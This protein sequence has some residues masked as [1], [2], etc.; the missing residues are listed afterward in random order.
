MENVS[1]E[2]K[3]KYLE[4][5]ADS[6]KVKDKRIDELTVGDWPYMSDYQKSKFK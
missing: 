5:R 4:M 2:M 1:D 3:K 6:T